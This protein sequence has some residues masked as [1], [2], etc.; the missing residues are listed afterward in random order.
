M[1]GRSLRVAAVV[2]AGVFT[3]LVV[4]PSGQAPATPQR[5][6]T[7][8]PAAKWTPPRTPWADPDLQGTWNNGTITPL[9]R[10]RGVGEKE[11]LSKEEQEEVN[12]QSDARAAVENRPRDAAQD[13][14]LAYDQVWWDR[15]KSIGRTSLIVEPKDGR[16]PP[17]TPQGEK[18]MAEREAVR[19]GRGAF[20]NS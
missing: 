12:E 13:V 14:E 4:S 19:A 15:G 5:S 6:T 10:P 20:G 3:L 18:L 7:S 1:A 9:E 17:L 2:L 11:L 16:L 8:K